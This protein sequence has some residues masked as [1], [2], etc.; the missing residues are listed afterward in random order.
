MAM[1]GLCVYPWGFMS[2]CTI[3]NRIPKDKHTALLIIHSLVLGISNNS[4]VSVQSERDPVLL[5]VCY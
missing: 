2:S 1:K 4:P 3:I 5:G